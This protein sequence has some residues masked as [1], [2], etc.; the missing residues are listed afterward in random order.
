RARLEQRALSVAQVR[1]RLED[2][3]LDVAEPKLVERVEQ[4]NS[5]LAG[6]GTELEHARLFESIELACERERERAR[7]PRPKLRRRHEIAGRAEL[8]AAGA[9]V[10]ETRRV[11][12]GFHVASEVDVTARG[13]YL[14]AQPCA[15][16]FGQRERVRARCGQGFGEGAHAASAGSKRR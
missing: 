4:L 6:A 9:V 7:E 3:V 10:A 5:E 13:R 15:E 1:A 14:V 11:Q 2:A 16:R 12:H 8:R